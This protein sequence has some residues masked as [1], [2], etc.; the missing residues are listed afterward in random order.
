MAQVRGRAVLVC[1]LAA[2]TGVALAERKNGLTSAVTIKIKVPKAVFK[3][4]EPVDGK[5][6]VTNLYPAGLPAVFTSPQRGGAGDWKGRGDGT[7]AGGHSGL[8]AQW[9]HD[10]CR[11]L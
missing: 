11:G 2:S 8:W 1:V 4:G 3:V 5:V 7:T 9:Q 10:A 6:I